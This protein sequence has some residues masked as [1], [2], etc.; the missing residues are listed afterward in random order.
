MKEREDIISVKNNLSLPHTPDIYV[1]THAW[2][3]FRR[4]R[5]NVL[6]LHLIWRES[7]WV[8]EQAYLRIM[9][10]WLPRDVWLIFRDMHEKRLLVRQSLTK[11]GGAIITQRGRRRRKPRHVNGNTFT[12]LETIYGEYSKS[13][14]DDSLTS[15]DIALLVF[16]GAVVKP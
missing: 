2:V 9:E 7:S 13:F 6:P 3:E 14:P 5:P 11:E 8:L 1:I 10:K 16:S 15:I 12:E 4:R